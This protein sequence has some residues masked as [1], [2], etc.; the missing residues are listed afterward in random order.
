MSL[1]GCGGSS[2]SSNDTDTPAQSGTAT[3]GVDSSPDILTI[4]TPFEFDDL[5]ITFGPEVTQTTIDTQYGGHEGATSTAIPMAIINNSDTTQGLNMFYTIYGSRGTKFDSISDHFT[6]TD[7]D[8]AG[9]ARSG[10]TTET[11]IHVLYTEPGDYVVKFSKPLSSD[12]I[13]GVLP[14]NR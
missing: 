12:V 14:L 3:E 6:D 4:D 10:A 7:V 5:T 8:W 9:K 11:I 1:R 2:G 13:E